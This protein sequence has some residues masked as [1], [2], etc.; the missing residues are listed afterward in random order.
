MWLL[1]IEQEKYLDY[2]LH[3]YSSKFLLQDSES[4]Y[5]CGVYVPRYLY[6]VC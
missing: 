1:Q 5:V 3:Y 6:Y 4:G 2:D